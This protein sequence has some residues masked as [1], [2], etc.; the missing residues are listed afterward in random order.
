[1]TD[2]PGMTAD[3][4]GMTVPVE[5]SHDRLARHDSTCRSEP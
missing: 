2:L 5:M 3:W 4:L 1:M